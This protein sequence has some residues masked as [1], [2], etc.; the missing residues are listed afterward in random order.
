MILNGKVIT[1]MLMV[2]ENR[3]GEL[4]GLVDLMKISVFLLGSKLG[5]VRWVGILSNLDEKEVDE[6]LIMY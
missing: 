2:K 1:Q 3:L 4:G 5:K 6:A